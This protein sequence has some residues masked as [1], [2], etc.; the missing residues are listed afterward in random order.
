MPEVLQTA[1]CFASPSYREGLGIAAIEA[2]LCEVPL[3]AAD[4]RGTREYAKEG[5][6]ALICRAG[7]TEAFAEA[8]QKLYTDTMLRIE[9]S[10][11]CRKSAQPFTVEEVEK[12]MKSIYKEAESHL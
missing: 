5:K 9:L 4:N 10:S 12:T 8:I 3:I 11:V 1:D 6:N 7:D 2:L